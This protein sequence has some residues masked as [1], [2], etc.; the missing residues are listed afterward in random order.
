M[1]RRVGTTV[2]VPCNQKHYFMFQN[3]KSQFNC[4]FEC[5]KQALNE[6]CSTGVLIESYMKVDFLCL[7]VTVVI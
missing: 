2:L 4:E 1:I 6:V 3:Y 7:S 5:F